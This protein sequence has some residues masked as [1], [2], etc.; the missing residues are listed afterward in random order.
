MQDSQYGNKDVCGDIV[1]TVVQ[2]L[3]ENINPLSY[4]ITGISTE[5]VTFSE[6]VSLAGH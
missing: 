6:D 2:L 3:N 4:V 1:Y 5:I